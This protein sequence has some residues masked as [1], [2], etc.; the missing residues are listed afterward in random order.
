MRQNKIDRTVNQKNKHSGIKTDRQTDRTE[1]NR[2][3]RK[4]RTERHQ[5]KQDRANKQT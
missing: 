4:S 1:K 5:D 2:L 3:D